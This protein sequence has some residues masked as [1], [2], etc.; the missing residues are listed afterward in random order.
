M[1]RVLSRVVYFALRRVSSSHETAAARSPNAPRSSIVLRERGGRD[2]G[3][4]RIRGAVHLW[5]RN[6]IEAGAIRKATDLSSLQISPPLTLSAE[7]FERL[8]HALSQSLQLP[9]AALLCDRATFKGLVGAEHKL[10]Y[11]AAV[12]H[13]QPYFYRV[14]MN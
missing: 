4:R 7:S 2:R 11:L 5:Q 13:A 6:E 12:G 9:A 1:N 3:A 14:E 8:W 10:S